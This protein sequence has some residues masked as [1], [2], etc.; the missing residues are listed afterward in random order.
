MNGPDY[1]RVA[2]TL[3]RI[4]LRLASKSERNETETEGADDRVLPG[5]D[6]GAGG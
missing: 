5:L 4:A 6:R 3:V 2:S 1:A